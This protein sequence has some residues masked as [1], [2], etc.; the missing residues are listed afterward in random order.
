NVY[1]WR[2]QVDEHESSTVS[3]ALFVKLNTIDAVWTRVYYAGDIC[4]H[5]FTGKG[6]E[7]LENHLNMWSSKYLA[8]LNAGERSAKI[9]DAKQ[10]IKNFPNQTIRQVA[11]NFPPIT[12]Y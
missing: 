8:R 1:Y 5:S 9:Y 12:C 7:T 10:W 2:R 11:R 3:L 4:V 6:L